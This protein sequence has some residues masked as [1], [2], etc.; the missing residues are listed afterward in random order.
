MHIAVA[1]GIALFAFRKLTN[2]V[3]AE[4]YS[5]SNREDVGWL[6]VLMCEALTVESLKAIDDA[7]SRL[8]GLFRSKRAFFQNIGEFSVGRFE[9]RIDEMGTIEDRLATGLQFDRFSC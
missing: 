4:L 3:A 9:D 2:A 8:L 5:L 7:D 6:Y 1:K